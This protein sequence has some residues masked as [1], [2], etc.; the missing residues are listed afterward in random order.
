MGKTTPGLPICLRPIG[1]VRSV[2]TERTFKRL[3]MTELFA[4]IVV[5]ESL[6]EGLDGLK[7][8]SHIIVL[9]WMHLA[10][11]GT[12]HL[13]GHPRGDTSTSK[14]VFALRSPDRPNPIGK[15]TVRLLEIK[16]NVL[17]VQGLDAIDGTPVLDIKPFIPGY[18]SAANPKTPDWVVI[19]K[20]EL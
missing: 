8:F 2:M 6:L 11:Q 18:D 9:Y 15:S 12:E 17:R 3:K 5:D 10:N 7:D 13:K 4:E 20:E 14:G 1:F 16:G 19:D